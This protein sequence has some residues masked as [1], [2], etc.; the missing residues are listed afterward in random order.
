MSSFPALSLPQQLCPHLCAFSFFRSPG[1]ITPTWSLSPGD[2]V[3]LSRNPSLAPV[4]F[5]AEG[6][7][8]LY[9]FFLFSLI[10][11]GRKWWLLKVLFISTLSKYLM[12]LSAFEGRIK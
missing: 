8:H 2:V 12:D 3:T 6:A 1:F 10:V 11:L 9:F 5:S 7:I 4:K